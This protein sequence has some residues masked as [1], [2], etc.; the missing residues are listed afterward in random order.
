MVFNVVLN[1][2]KLNLSSQFSFIL[3]DCAL[4]IVSVYLYGRNDFFVD[5]QSTAFNLFKNRSLLEIL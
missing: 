4:D 1:K 2:A 5:M 3:N